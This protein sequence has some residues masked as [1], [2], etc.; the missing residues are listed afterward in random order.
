MIMTTDIAPTYGGGPIPCQ[1]YS[2]TNLQNN[3]KGRYDHPH[4]INEDIKSKRL[5]NL[6]MVT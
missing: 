3:P 6:L 2:N 5:S 1:T 4:F